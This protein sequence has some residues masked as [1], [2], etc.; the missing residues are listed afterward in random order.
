MEPGHS[1]TVKVRVGLGSGVYLFV[2]VRVR[3]STGTVILH[4]D[5]NWECP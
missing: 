3:K 2:S 1:N 4:A 5:E